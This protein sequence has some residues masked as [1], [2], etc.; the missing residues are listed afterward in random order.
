MAKVCWEAC[1]WWEII[2]ALSRLLISYFLVSLFGKLS[3]D[4]IESFSVL[5]W[6]VWRERNNFV[7]GNLVRNAP[8]ILD[9]A[10]RFLFDYQQAKI[11]I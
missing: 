8:D 2:R 5:L 3:K 11:I 9:A 4:E 6:F 10:G 1:A 7:H